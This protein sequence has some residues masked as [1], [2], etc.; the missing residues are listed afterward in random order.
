[1]K[2]RTEIINKKVFI[3]CPSKT[4]GKRLFIEVP[5]EIKEENNMDKSTRVK[6]EVLEDN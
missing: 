1:M 4:D 5:L 3:K 2:K 6:C